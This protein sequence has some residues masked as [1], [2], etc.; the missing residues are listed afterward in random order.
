MRMQ[1][2][3]PPHLYGSAVNF[4]I[5]SVLAIVKYTAQLFEVFLTHTSVQIHEFI[6]FFPPGC[7]KSHHMTSS[8]WCRKDSLYIH[9]PSLSLQSSS[10]LY[11][12]CYLGQVSQ[13]ISHSQTKTIPRY[14]VLL[15]N[16]TLVVQK[17]GLPHICGIQ[18]ENTNAVN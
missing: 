9:I 8:V 7:R 6:S 13:P 18:G 12:S 14:L 11:L 17:A 4:L 10:Q 5:Y 2:L 16:C 3:K 1:H 15:Q